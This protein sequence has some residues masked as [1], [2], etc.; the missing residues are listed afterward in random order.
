MSDQPTPTSVTAPLQ[1]H[2]EAVVRDKAGKVLAACPDAF[3]SNLTPE[4]QARARRAVENA[5]TSQLPA[6]YALSAFTVV[7]L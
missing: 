4:Q 3:D 2:F 1:A 5:S 6:S 7:F